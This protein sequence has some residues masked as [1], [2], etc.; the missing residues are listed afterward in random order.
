MQMQ[1]ARAAATAMHCRFLRGDFIEWSA[2]GG[3]APS[4][5][6]IESLVELL[7]TLG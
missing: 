2:L 7:R 5:V 1:M 6:C 3:A 4:G